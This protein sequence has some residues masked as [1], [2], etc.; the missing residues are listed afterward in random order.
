MSKLALI[1]G[2]SSGIGATFARALASRGYDLVLVARR[3]ERLDQLAAELCAVHPIHA[4]TL[5]ADLADDAS[6]AVVEERL[7]SDPNLELLV[8]NAGFGDQGLFWKTDLAMQDRM[9]RVHVLATLRLNH[10]ALRNLVAH[11]RGGIIN[12][13]SV[14][15]FIRS[16]G[17]ASY[18]STKAW[19]NS[20]TECVSLELKI[21]RSP[22]KIQALC[23]GFTY[24]E[25]HDT[26]GM[27]RKTIPSWWWMQ[28]EDIVE[29]SLE[30]LD[31][32]KLFV[33]PGFGYKL[34]TT[35]VWRL[36]RFLLHPFM[37]RYGRR[38]RPD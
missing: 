24:T 22:V 25:F 29:A 10:A 5:V 6:R 33:V 18:N 21:A 11:G 32:G 34:V 16:P 3:K 35:V 31:R 2:A 13:A 30:G 37:L 20:F 23:P 26:M 27:D 36:P 7:A 28:A 15:G 14:A 1:T 19:M 8:N 4:E 17:T 38:R 9:H 12:V